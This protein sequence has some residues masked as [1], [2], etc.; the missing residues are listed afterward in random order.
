LLNHLAPTTLA[1]RPSTPPTVSAAPSTSKSP[2][3]WKLAFDKFRKEEPKLVPDYD[4]HVLGNAAVSAD[5]S[6]RE[7]VEAAVKTLLEDRE[8]KQWKIHLPGQDIKIRTQ[9]E[10]FVKI[11]QWSD[12]LVKDAVSTQ[13]Y[14]ALAW[15]GVSL[16]L[17]ASSS[18]ACLAAKL[19]L[20]RTAPHKRYHAE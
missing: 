12:P 11:L 3:P 2:D 16:L 15:S 4:K 10:R 17:P 7:S 19:L 1:I 18:I 5:L 20:T 9:V 8:K 14:A 13:P 6:N